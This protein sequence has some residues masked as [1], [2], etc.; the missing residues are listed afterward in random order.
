MADTRNQTR[1]P[2][3]HA[4]IIPGERDPTNLTHREPGAVSGQFSGADIPAGPLPWL[5]DLTVHDRA[6]EGGGVEGEHT[7][8]E[9]ET[10][11]RQARTPERDDKGD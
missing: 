5:D 4:P 7:L 1:A 3:A 11:D 6:R 8:A 9:R 2:D 10:R